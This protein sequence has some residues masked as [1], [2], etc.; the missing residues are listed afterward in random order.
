M[1]DIESLRALLAAVPEGPWEFQSAG[2]YECSEPACCSEY[3]DDRVWA[4]GVVLFEACSDPGVAELVAV[5]ITALPGILDRLEAAEAERDE[6]KRRRDNAVETCRFRHQDGLT[7]REWHL[8]ICAAA[9]AAEAA[10]RALAELR[11]QI[12]GEIEA[13]PEEHGD[14]WPVRAYEI[15]ADAASIARGES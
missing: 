1:T 3:W 13:L 11:E 2:K 14:G 7:A 10:E 5:A 9:Q 4:N 8:N 12:A 15:K 6:W